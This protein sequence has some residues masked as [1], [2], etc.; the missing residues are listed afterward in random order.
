[1]N[2]K[3]KDINRCYNCL[4]TKH[5]YLQTRK[6]QHKQEYKH[7]SPAHVTPEVNQQR[8]LFVTPIGNH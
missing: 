3:D 1:M 7:T 2:D 5:T 6:R 8:T 4:H